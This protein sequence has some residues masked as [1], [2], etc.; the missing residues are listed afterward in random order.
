VITLFCDGL[1]LTNP[2]NGSQANH[3]AK[4]SERKRVK[5]WVWA[6]GM[7]SRVK[8]DEP[9]KQSRV[10]IT[11][12]APRALDMDGLYASIKP[13]ADALKVGCLD[14]IVD[15][16]PGVCELIAKQEKGQ[17]AVRIEVEPLT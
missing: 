12:Y 9:F 8:P 10:T 15:D 16:R 11:R 6:I 4:A 2:L 1:R 17:Y 7:E 13:C 5:Q 14:I 3:W